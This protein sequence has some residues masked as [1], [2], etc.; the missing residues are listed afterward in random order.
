MLA[1]SPM[2][3][4][5]FEACCVICERCKDGPEDL[6]IRCRSI[7]KGNPMQV[8]YFCALTKSI[9]TLNTSPESVQD[10]IARVKTLFASGIAMFAQVLNDD[11]LV[12]ENLAPLRVLEPVPLQQENA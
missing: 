9:E 2:R 7:Y 3:Q 12:L 1:R 6:A 8:V 10:A 4:S 5:C 11:G